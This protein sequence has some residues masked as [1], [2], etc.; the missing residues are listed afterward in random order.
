MQRHRDL[1]RAH[2]E[3]DGSSWHIESVYSRGTGRK[4]RDKRS[5][6]NYNKESK[7]CL[8]NNK[9]C[10]GSADCVSYDEW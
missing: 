6:T 1:A 8:L 7:C 10:T 9:I 5:C 3:L 2:A 4:R